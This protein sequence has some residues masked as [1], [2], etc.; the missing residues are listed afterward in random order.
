[1]VSNSRSAAALLGMVALVGCGGDGSGFGS[2]GNDDVYIDDAR[3]SC[4]PTA[5]AWDDLFIFK[6]WTGNAVSVQ[7]TVKDGGSTLDRVSLDEEDDQYWYRE[8]W[9]DDL[10]TD[11]DDFNSLRFI[12]EAEGDNGSTQEIELR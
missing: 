7:V 10:G 11:C 12:V 6:A 3:A 5:S 9:A 4:D 2:S 1:M 8:V